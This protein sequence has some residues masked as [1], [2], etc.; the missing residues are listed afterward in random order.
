MRKKNKTGAITL[1]DIRQYCTG[2]INQ[3]SMVLAQKQTHGSMEENR[4]LRDNPPHLSSINL[5]QRR[6][7]YMMEKRQ[8]L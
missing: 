1:P 3:N 8:S 7:V 2:T 4:E 6:K 5:C